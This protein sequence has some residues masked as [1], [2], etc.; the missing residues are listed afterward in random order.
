MAGFWETSINKLKKNNEANKL[1]AEA[2]A[3]SMLSPRSST[4]G[5]RSRTGNLKYFEKICFVCN[6]KLPCYS[7][8]YNEGRWG[9]YEFKSAGNR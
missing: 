5:T 6:K 9:V 8:A 2:A 1:V 4:T 3:A 7:N